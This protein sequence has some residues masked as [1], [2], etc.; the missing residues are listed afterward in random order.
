[1]TFWLASCI[2]SFPLFPLYHSFS[3]SSSYSTYFVLSSELDSGV[4]GNTPECSLLPTPLMLSV[5][6]TRVTCQDPPLQII[7]FL[8]GHGKSCSSCHTNSEGSNLIQLDWWHPQICEME[9]NWSFTGMFLLQNRLRPLFPQDSAQM[10]HLGETFYR[11]TLFYF[12][13]STY[14]CPKFFFFPFFF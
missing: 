8:S 11:I 10:A 4:C 1:M 12:P 9:S 14:Q 5:G 6:K 7:P 2:S 3:Y 13:Q